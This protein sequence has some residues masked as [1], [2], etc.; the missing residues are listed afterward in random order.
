[1]ISLL[2]D[3]RVGSSDFPSRLLLQDFLLFADIADTHFIILFSLLLS[4]GRNDVSLCLFALS[5][6][7]PHNLHT[8]YQP[9][10]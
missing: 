9:T 10:I 3:I 8:F 6:H 4:L 5:N 7:Y 1:M 2:P